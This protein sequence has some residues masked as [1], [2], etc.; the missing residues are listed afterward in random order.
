M[1]CGAGKNVLR[2]EM[3]DDEIYQNGIAILAAAAEE[4]LAGGAMQI[5][6]QLRLRSI[7]QIE[8]HRNSVGETAIEY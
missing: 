2:F 4:D 7:D 8:D 1:L 3:P 5:Q 6:L